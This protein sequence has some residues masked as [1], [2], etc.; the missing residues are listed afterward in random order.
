[1]RAL[2]TQ[3]SGLIGLLTFLS[4]LMG[5]APLEKTILMGVGTGL[6]VYMVLLIGDL[7]IQRILE[8]LH[9]VAPPEPEEKPE[10]EANE[11]PPSETS[12]IKSKAM[13]A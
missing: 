9:Q 8:Q 11:H 7:V 1:M 10:G 13:A 3:F 2:F 6:F 12:A 4:Q 5:Q